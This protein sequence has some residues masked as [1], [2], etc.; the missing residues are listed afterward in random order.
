VAI[1]STAERIAKR[2]SRPVLMVRQLPH[3]A[4]RRV[5]V[6]V[7]FS[8][9]SLSAIE[10]ARQVAPQASMVLMHAVEMPYE[11]KMH[12]AGVG[13]HVVAQYREA[14][15]LEAL[16][17]LSDLAADAGLDASR[18]RLSAPGGADP[19]MLIAQE[20]LEQDCDLVVIGRQGRH[21]LDEFLLGSTTRMVV[22]E[23]TADVLICS[24]RL[25][26]HP[27]ASASA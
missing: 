23:G 24:R 11:G 14:A 27:P 12:L 20:E 13:E 26:R 6:P 4:Y 15:R 7:D 8:D 9:W 5:L 3:E 10:L 17:R 19:W 1:G 18:L 21:A 16:Q 2:S 22:A 25:H